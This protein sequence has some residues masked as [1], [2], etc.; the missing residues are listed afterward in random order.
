MQLAPVLTRLLQAISTAD[1]DEF[2]EVCAPDAVIYDGGERFAG[3]SGLVE[4]FAM[5]ATGGHVELLPL[6]VRCA[7][8]RHELRI[9]WRCEPFHGEPIVFDI[10]MSVLI[11]TDRL[12]M[13]EITSLS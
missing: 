5:N 2:L 11:T 7:R 10:G 8:G 12:Q 1:V 3:R 4:W 6:E 13:L 9:E